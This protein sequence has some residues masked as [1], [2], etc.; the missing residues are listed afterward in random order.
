MAAP[1][2]PRSVP[3]ELTS[4]G[5]EAARWG[6]DRL[7]LL[8]LRT[9][10][11]VAAARQTLTGIGALDDAVRITERGRQIAQ[12]PTDPRLARALVDGASLVGSRRAAEVVALLAEDVRAPGADLVAALRAMRGG[13]GSGSWRAQLKRL[14]AL[15]GSCDRGSGLERKRAGWGKRGAGS[16]E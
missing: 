12:V 4:F 10:P 7:F 13:R 9:A 2:V 14:E 3:A 11:A 16:V 1:L 6:S 8:D 15:A 5:L